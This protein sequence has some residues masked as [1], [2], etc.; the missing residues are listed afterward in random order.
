VSLAES[1]APTVDVVI[2][3]RNEA[4]FLGQCLTALAAQDYPLDRVTVYVVD[5]GSTD[6]TASIASGFEHPKLRVRL[7]HHER[8]GAGAARNAAIRT[9]DSALLGLLDAHC[10]VEPGWLPALVAR[11][12]EPEIGGC[13]ARIVSRATDSRVARY[14]ER[15]GEQ[16]NERILD[17][18][19]RGKRNLYP[20]M[21]S[22]N[23][24]YRR[25]A[26]ET[27]GGFDEQL[28][29]CEDVDL[30]WRVVLRGYRLAYEHDAVA[31]HYDTNSW[32]RFIRKGLV[33]GAGAAELTRRYAA[34]GAK[35][36]FTPSSVWSVNLDRSLSAAFYGVGYRTT[37]LRMR[38][39]VHAPP[40]AVPRSP[41]TDD[42][43]PWF[44]WSSDHR[45]RLSPD[46]VFWLRDDTDPESVVVHLPTH[47]R[48]VLD[49][50]GDRIWRSL[51]AAHSRETTI[52]GLSAFY[53]IS[54]ITAAADLDDFIEELVA[55]RFLERS[56]R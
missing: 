20:W 32:W 16:S 3:A 40:T 11:F 50:V 24:M 38:L 17:D 45:A 56:D 46:C 39:G 52:A 19:V 27:A 29:A 28:R 1:A 7:I 41:V 25:T 54:P 31:V 13:Q 51:A 5:N 10:L 2:P 49:G 53:G 9:G 30:G 18:T 23:S 55:G 4:R 35:N 44:E 6:D 43:R 26:V 33:Y 12:R 14:L 21:L 37:A 15:S 34:H 47:T 48:L 42:F 36:K 22:G 8:R